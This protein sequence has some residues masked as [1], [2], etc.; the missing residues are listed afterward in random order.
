MI[1]RNFIV[2]SP[3]GSLQDLHDLSGLTC[4]S[5]LILHNLSGAFPPDWRWW[6]LR[7]AIGRTLFQ[8]AH[9]LLYRAVELRVSARD[10]VLGPVLDIDVRRDAFV[11]HRPL[12]LACE[13]PAARSDH[14]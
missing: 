13:E 12:P 7:R 1:E 4:K 5:C 10:N 9:R 14:R 3:E 11:L 6:L 2:T 8:Q